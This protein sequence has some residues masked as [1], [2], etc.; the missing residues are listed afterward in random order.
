MSVVRLSNQTKSLVLSG[1]LFVTLLGMSDVASAQ[2]PTQAQ[3]NAI[4]QSCAADYRAHC[5]SVPTGGSAALACLQQNA[6][7]AT[8]AC[9]QAL[10]TIGREAAPQ[11]GQTQPG[12]TQTDQTPVGPSSLPPAS[13]PVTLPPLTPR[14]QALVL[15]QACAH[16][17]QRLCRNVALGGG[18]AIACLDQNASALSPGCRNTLASMRQGRSA[19]PR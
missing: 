19:Q 4:R 7:S 14:Q 2:Q 12:Q 1:L 9:Q 8:P 5:A 17:Y 13:A 3:A 15:R 18:R 16:D 10:A 11:T 6:A